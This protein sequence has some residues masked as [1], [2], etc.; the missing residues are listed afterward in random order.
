MKLAIL[1]AGAMGT[2]CSIIVADKPELELVLWTH[3]ASHAEQMQREHENRLFFPGYPL[4]DRVQVTADIAAAVEGAQLLLIAI[5]TVYLRVALEPLADA[6]PAGVPIASVAKG[7]E[8]QTFLRPSEIIRDKLG[9]HSLAALC[10]PS[11]D[12]KARGKPASVVAA[13]S[14]ADLAVLVQ[15]TF[16]TERFRIYTNEDLLGVE[17]AGA[18]KNVVAIAAGICDGLELGDNAKSALLTRGLV[19]MV[20][21][22]TALGGQRETFYGLAGI[23]DLITTCVS[24]FGRNRAVGEKLGRGQTLDQIL[25]ATNA[26]AEGVWTARAV[27]DKARPLGIEMPITEEICQVLFEQ[28]PPVD[29]VRDLMTRSMKSE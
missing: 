29:A 25:A 19:E 27:R 16:S 24:P 22:G 14:D 21:F 1:G 28:K 17:L 4:G 26:V 20:R 13:S 11:P 5:P 7:L 8:Q 12:E 3:D 23:G 15:E 10:G 18:L 2:A 9:D 6:I